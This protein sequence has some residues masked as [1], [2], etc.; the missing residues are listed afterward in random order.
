MYSPSFKDL[1]EV[2]SD[3]LSSY[4]QLPESFS[5]SLNLLIGHELSNTWQD[6]SSCIWPT[7]EFTHIL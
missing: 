4:F 5:G 1:S 7:M 6:F 3:D 2:M